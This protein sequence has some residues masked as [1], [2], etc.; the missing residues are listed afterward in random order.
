MEKVDTAGTLLSVA[1]LPGGRSRVVR[2]VVHTFCASCASLAGAH[3]NPRL[4]VT[5]TPQQA[6][7]ETGKALDVD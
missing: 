2:A 7:V 5:C 6:K 3:E 1:L 4:G